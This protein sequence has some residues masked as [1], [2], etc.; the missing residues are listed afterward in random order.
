MIRCCAATQDA[1]LLGKPGCV[2]RVVEWLSSA[3]S[4]GVQTVA[5]PSLSRTPHFAHEST[6]PSEENG[7]AVTPMAESPCR[8]AGGFLLE[9]AQTGADAGGEEVDVLPAPPS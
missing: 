5:P 7:A 8:S 1:S 3:P 9:Q 6:P 4:L 2:G